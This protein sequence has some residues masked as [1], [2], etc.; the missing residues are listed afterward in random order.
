MPS[1]TDRT[2]QDNEFQV[3]NEGE[4]KNKTKQYT[5]KKIKENDQCFLEV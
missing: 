2:L 3:R 5:R 1:L 4:S